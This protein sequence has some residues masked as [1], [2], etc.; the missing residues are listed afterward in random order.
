MSAQLTQIV[1]HGFMEDGEFERYREPQRY[2]VDASNR[3]RLVRK[4]GTPRDDGWVWGIQDLGFVEGPDGPVEC[5][6]VT[7][8][9]WER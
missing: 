2:A 6:S 9:R 5:I 7:R 4:Y 3:A 1:E 8:I